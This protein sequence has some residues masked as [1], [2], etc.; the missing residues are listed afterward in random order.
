MFLTNAMA[1]TENGTC[2][3]CANETGI[4]SVVTYILMTTT[5]TAPACELSE[6]RVATILNSA[7]LERAWHECLAVWEDASPADRAN[8]RA[9][10]VALR[11]NFLRILR[12]IDD[13]EEQESMA[14]IFYTQVKSQWI[15]INTQS[16]Y[17]I[18]RGHIDGSLFCRAG[19]LSALLGALE[20]IFNEADLARITNFLAQ[21]QAAV[22]DSDARV[23]VLSSLIGAPVTLADERS[24]GR[25]AGGVI[26]DAQALETRLS[27]LNARISLLEGERHTLFE[28]SGA[29]DMEGVLALLAHQD[30]EPG[31]A[32]DDKRNNVTSAAR[33]EWNERRELLLHDLR[34]QVGRLKAGWE[35]VRSETGADDA[36]A[37]VAV[38]RANG[39]ALTLALAQIH[40]DNERLGALDAE[41]SAGV[42]AA[43]IV[44]ARRDALSEIARWEAEVATLGANWAAVERECGTSDAGE[45]VALVRG[46]RDRVSAPLGQMN[47]ADAAGLQ[48]E[49]GARTVPEAAALL[50]QMRD[51]LTETRREL[52][53]LR[54]GQELFDTALGMTDAR[55]ITAHVR[56]MREREQNLSEMA[57]LLGTIEDSMRGLTN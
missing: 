15:L 44:A 5:K 48:V 2:Q 29:P 39:D 17:Q 55:E 26:V 1:C 3:F 53:E 28:E 32:A 18:Q 22:R 10:A 33:A 19:M 6:A 27:A 4:G 14:A 21:P 54:A 23:H 40:T 30:V 38:W 41:F 56:A 57:S 45:I 31:A 11:D 25:D 12:D 8:A 24:D 50:R 13:A 46:L 49:F 34:K 20:P 43:E 35:Q 7:E 51:A 36:T 42:S 52:T 37:L 16:G 47:A 9:F